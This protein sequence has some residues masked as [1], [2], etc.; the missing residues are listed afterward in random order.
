MK[1]GVPALLDML[2]HPAWVCR[3]LLPGGVPR[4][5]N[6]LEFLPAG[7]GRQAA[8]VGVRYLATQLNPLFSW[9]AVARLRERWRGRLV[10][11]GILSVEDARRAA[12]LGADGVGLPARAGG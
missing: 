2:A 5:E 7:G 1:L 12:D 4:F 6:L 9:A 3:V 11:K 10:L 8:R